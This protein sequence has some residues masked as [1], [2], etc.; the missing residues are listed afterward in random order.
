MSDATETPETGALRHVPLIAILLVAIVGAFT[1]RDYLSFDALAEH[2]EALIAFRDAHYLLTALGFMAVYILIVAFS[3]PG[4]TIATLTGGFLFGLFPGALLNITGATIG[5]TAIFLAARWGMGAKLAA[6][7]DASGGMA[8]HLKDAIRENELSVLFLIRL[9][10]AV[11]FVVANIIPAL[12]GVSLSRFVFT[13]FFGIIPGGVVYTWVGAG[14]GEVFARGETP[15]LGIIFE[16][17]ILGPILGLCAL[18]AL[19]IVIK[20]IRRKKDI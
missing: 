20:A 14:L 18:A 8:G 2:R 12:V 9:V 11:P 1:L 10:P 3:L 15:N 16:P 5:A 6:K 17:Q 7:M 13:T 4:A 19:P